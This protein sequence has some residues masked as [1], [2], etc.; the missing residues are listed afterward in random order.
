MGLVDTAC[1]NKHTFELGSK[2]TYTVEH[3]S[4]GKP[5]SELAKV[6][7]CKRACGSTAPKVDARRVNAID[8][9]VG[10]FLVLGDDHVRVRRSVR[11][12]VV[13]GVLDIVNNLDRTFHIRV[14]KP[15]R[16][17]SEAQ[18]AVVHRER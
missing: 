16:P 10:R 12:D 18:R 4:K 17:I 7:F 6:P 5:P 3:G 15:V 2:C 8:E 13:D 9:S 11:V 14:P 1:I